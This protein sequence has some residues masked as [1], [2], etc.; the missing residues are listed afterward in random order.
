MFKKRLTSIL[1]AGIL[2]RADSPPARPI[3]C[4]VKGKYY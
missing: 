4:D 3:M 2:E 1:H